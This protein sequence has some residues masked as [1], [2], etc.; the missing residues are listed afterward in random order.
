MERLAAVGAEEELYL[1]LADLAERAALTEVTIFTLEG[2][3]IW[4][5]GE[6]TTGGRSLAAM[7]TY[8]I[9]SD[10][11]ART[12]LRFRVMND[13]D[14]PE[15]SPQTDILLQ[16]LVDR[17]S[18]TLIRLGSPHA[19]RIPTAARARASLVSPETVAAGE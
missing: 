9:G 16:V 8:P 7:M 6:E 17:V 1:E 13:D 10:A 15:M 4:R 12:K 2:E 5:H 18:E 14:D 3:M 19:P 11:A